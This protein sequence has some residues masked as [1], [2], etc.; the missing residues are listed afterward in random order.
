[1]PWLERSMHWHDGKA[2]RA[3]MSRRDLGHF[4]RAE[5]KG[6][7]WLNAVARPG[8][9]ARGTTQ[10][11]GSHGQAPPSVQEP[12]RANQRRFRASEQKLSKYGVTCTVDGASTDG[13]RQGAPTGYGRVIMTL[14]KGTLYRG[15]AGLQISLHTR[16]VWV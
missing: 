10:A 14:M 16:A 6:R 13:L 5:S 8:P 3:G 12:E 11:L 4:G 7:G 15:F 2:G 9:R 1:M